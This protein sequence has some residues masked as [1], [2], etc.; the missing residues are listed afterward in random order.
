MY[1]TPKNNGINYQP[2]L[3]QDFSHQQY[4]SWVAPLTKQYLTEMWLVLPMLQGAFHFIE[5]KRVISFS[6]GR[7]DTSYRPLKPPKIPKKPSA[8]R[9]QYS[10][11]PWFCLKTDVWLKKFHN[12]GRNLES[13]RIYIIY[14]N[15]YKY[16]YILI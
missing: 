6:T 14:I 10:P 1:E 5:G 3:V 12:P 13:G 4:H 11:W 9:F 7:L 15:N 8:W 16:I 2:Q